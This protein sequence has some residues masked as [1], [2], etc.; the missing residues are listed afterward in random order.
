MKI[1]RKLATRS[2][3]VAMLV[4]AVAA[5]VLALVWSP[6]QVEGQL[7]G[8]SEVT[9]LELGYVVERQ[10]LQARISLATGPSLIYEP[11]SERDSD[12][13]LKMA[14]IFGQRG[15]RMFVSVKDDKIKS[16]QLSSP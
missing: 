10:A 7:G 1:I 11:A 4:P 2:R 9:R 12:T 13:L 5:L 3:W 16:F 8:Y 6:R 14:Q 15:T